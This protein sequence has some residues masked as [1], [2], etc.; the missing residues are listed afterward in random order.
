MDFNVSPLVAM[1]SRINGNEISV[2]DEIVME[3]SNTFEMVEELLNRYPNNR[4]W[5]YPDA[6]G[7][8]RKTSS[9]TS[10]HHILRNAGFVLKVRNINPPVKDRIASVNAS[11]KAT[12]G[13]VKLT[14][15][16]KCR[17]LIKCISSQTYKEGTQIPDKS[18]NLDH[19][20]DSC[21]YL[22]HWI[23][24]IRRDRPEHADRGPQ[25]F[26]HY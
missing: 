12:D 6:S 4:I 17:H 3:G 21:G 1:V 25:L 10:D 5:V 9:N 8:A 23:N 26:G 7:Q 16:P 2:I 18:G 19:M 22:V 14:V 20:A 13:T 11:L 24:P 15:D